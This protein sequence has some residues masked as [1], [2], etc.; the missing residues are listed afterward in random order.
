MKSGRA[1]LAA[2]AFAMFASCGPPANTTASAQ[3]A[4]PQSGEYSLNARHASIVFRVNHMGFSRTVGR[5][6]RFDAALTLDADAPERSAFTATV[7]AASIDSGLPSFDGFLRGDRF[8]N[9]DANPQIR[10]V[11]R[12]V[13]RTGERTAQVRGDLTMNGA[14]HPASF[15]VVLNGAGPHPF[16]GR[17]M[18]GFSA[19]GHVSRAQFGLNAFPQQVSDE[20]EILIEAEFARR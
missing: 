20:I 16:D 17:F 4:L 12:A 8:L 6:N 13:E 2:L 11:S 1:I 18:A 10:F 9:T 19:I 14:T 5:F 3:Q 15:E 7:E